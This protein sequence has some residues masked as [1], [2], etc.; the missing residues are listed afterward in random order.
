MLALLAAVILLREELYT[1]PFFYLL[2]ITPTRDN[3]AEE[4]RPPAQQDPTEEEFQDM[5][6]KAML[7]MEAEAMEA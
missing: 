7:E 1:Y 3:P 5:E 2:S 4:E 6:Q